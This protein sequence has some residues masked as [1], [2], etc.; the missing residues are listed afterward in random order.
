MGASTSATAGSVRRARVLSRQKSYA[1]RLA[2]SSIS[3][4]LNVP[5]QKW[6]PPLRHAASYTA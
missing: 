2:R 6:K 3:T 1:V 5:A 4:S